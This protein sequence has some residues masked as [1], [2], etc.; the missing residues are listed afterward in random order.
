MSRKRAS[1]ALLSGRR[2][3]DSRKIIGKDNLGDPIY[4]GEERTSGG[5]INILG[6]RVQLDPVTASGIV[7]LVLIAQFFGV[8]L[9]QND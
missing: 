6:A 2:R 1:T 9:F 8:G 3:K 7:F 4:E 5:G